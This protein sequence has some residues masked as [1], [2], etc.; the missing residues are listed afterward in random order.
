[1]RPGGSKQ[2]IWF[3]FDEDRPV[4][5]LAG[6]WTRWTSVRKI[7]EGEIT[8]N[9]F[10]FLT[11]QPNAEVWAVHPQAMPEILTAEE[12]ARDL[13]AGAMVGGEGVAAAPA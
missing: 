11:T 13:A 5:F 9:V 6:I 12:G 4:A 2:P 7:K 3:A 10:G 8:A 1:L